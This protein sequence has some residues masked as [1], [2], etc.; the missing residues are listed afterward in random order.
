MV[1]ARKI[2]RRC[3][4]RSTAL[5]GEPMFSYGWLKWFGDSLSNRPILIGPGWAV[6]VRELWAPYKKETQPALRWQRQ[7]PFHLSGRLSP[8]VVPTLPR[9]STVKLVEA[10]S[11]SRRW[12]C[13][14][15]EPILS[16]TGSRRWGGWG[17]AAPAT[18]LPRVPHHQ[19]QP[20]VK[21]QGSTVNRHV[22]LWT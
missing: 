1:K 12:Q 14:G 16:P 15:Y 6:I 19:G 2:E 8:S 10:P 21:P 4:P 17:P 22:S 11:R 5:E 9:Q 20:E 18:S 7:N 3:W 13:A